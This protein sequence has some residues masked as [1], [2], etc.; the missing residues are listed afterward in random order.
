LHVT[1]GGIDA[2]AWKDELPREEYMTRVTPTKQDFR[3]VVCLVDNNKSG[4]IP[5]LDACVKSDTLSL[6]QMA[7]R[8]WHDKLSRSPA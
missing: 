4:G 2:P 7:W 8:R 5:R 1:V 6:N 3:F